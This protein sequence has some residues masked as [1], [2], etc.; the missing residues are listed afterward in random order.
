MLVHLLQLLAPCSHAPR[1]RALHRLHFSINALFLLFSVRTSHV[2][3]TMRIA[4]FL[5]PEF[6]LFIAFA[7]NTVACEAN[8][9]CDIRWY[10]ELETTLG[11]APEQSNSTNASAVCYR[12]LKLRTQNHVLI[13]GFSVLNSNCSSI[14]Q[15]STKPVPIWSLLN[16]RNWIP[17]NLPSDIWNFN[18]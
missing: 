15:S 12:M 9:E 11:R 6:R 3:Q 17:C 5:T 4:S 13:A 1:H 8:L 16:E 2:L 7:Y 18:K 10:G 14:M